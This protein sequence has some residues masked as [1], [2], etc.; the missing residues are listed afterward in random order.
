MIA[1]SYHG[2][3]YALTAIEDTHDFTPF[4][5]AVEMTSYTGLPVELW[6][7]RQAEQAKAVRARAR[8]PRDTES[9]Q[10][11]KERTALNYA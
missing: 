11:Q 7:K 6:L 9:R 4:R 8:A 5:S 2:S 1:S 10:A 3:I